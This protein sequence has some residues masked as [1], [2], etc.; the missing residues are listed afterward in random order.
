M[1]AVNGKAMPAMVTG[2]DPRTVNCEHETLV[3]QDAV[4]VD[5]VLTRPVE[6]TYE[7][8]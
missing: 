4:V 5:V 6:P 7:R 2:E 3:P 1:L 8:P